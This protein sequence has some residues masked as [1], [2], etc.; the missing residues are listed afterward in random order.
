[1]IHALVAAVASTRNAVGQTDGKQYGAQTQC[2]N[3]VLEVTVFNI[4]F[5]PPALH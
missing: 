1:M 2:S 5:A 3:T 4:P